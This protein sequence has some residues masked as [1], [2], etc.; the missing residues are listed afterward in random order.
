MRNH[1]ILL[2]GIN[3]KSSYVRKI[4]LTD[5]VLSGY[6]VFGSDHYVFISF[7]SIVLKD[8]EKYVKSIL[9]QILFKFYYV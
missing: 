4:F 6:Y 3:L 1:S 2:H 9:K 8:T 7:L 5:D